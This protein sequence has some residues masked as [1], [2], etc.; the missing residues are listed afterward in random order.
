MAKFRLGRAKSGVAGIALMAC[1]AAPAQAQESPL[2]AGQYIL[3]GMATADT[4]NR[5]GLLMAVGQQDGNANSGGTGT[6]LYH[7]HLEYGLTDRLQIGATVQRFEDPITFAFGSPDIGIRGISGQVAYKFVDNERFQMTARASV[8]QYEFRSQFWNSRND[9]ERFIGSFHIP[10]SLELNDSLTVHAS[11]GVSVFP[12]DINGVPFY[13]VIP[14]AGIGATFKASERV[15]FYGLVNVPFGSNG[16][17]ISN[18]GAITNVPIWTV[19]GSFNL[20]PKAAID[21]YATNGMGA[22]PATQIL[23]FFPDG[24]D[25]VVGARVT[26]TPGRGPGYRP[27]YRGI[28]GERSE[29]QKRLQ[30]H[31]MTMASADTLDPGRIV[32]WGN[33]STDGHHGGGISF[34]PD[35]DLEVGLTG[36]RFAQDG[37]VPGA[38][39]PSTGGQYRIIG[40]LRFLDQHNGSP[41]SMA[42]NL[43]A[44]RNLNS[45]VGSLYLSLPT[46]YQV[47]DRVTVAAEPKIGAWGNQRHYGIG[48][49]ANYELFEGLDVIGEG[50][51]IDGANGN[52]WS[53]GARYTMKKLPVSLEVQATNAIS[54]Y[55]LG[56]MIAQDNVR[57]TAG[58]RIALD[59]RGIWNANVRPSLLGLGGR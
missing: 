20:T 52:I 18:T 29:R 30:F 58:V 57:Y 34:S 37:S 36:E 15:R 3:P 26:Y 44:G 12:E 40:K 22:T 43:V 42:A 59:G 38:F 31:G 45:R 25:I 5:G 13:G 21:L 48:L 16:N 51:V 10:A 53:L 6:Q 9:D 4:L 46:S 2:E 19:G 39:L 33:Y 1:L 24:D 7:W 50:A 11:A 14:Q 17:S 28:V 35:Y 23:T 55:G 54:N 49:G 56:T 32:A 8:E 47:N 27:N 41:V